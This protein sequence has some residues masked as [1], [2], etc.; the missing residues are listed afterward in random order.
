MA[1]TEQTIQCP[2]CGAEMTKVFLSD[3]GISIDVCNNGCGGIFFDNQELQTINASEND[4]EE[5]KKVLVGK[6]FQ[7]PDSSKV[8]VCPAC[9]SNMVKTKAF[10]TE[11]DTCYNCGA[12]FLDYNEIDSVKLQRHK[13]APEPANPNDEAIG[14]L[15]IHEFYKEAQGE[16]FADNWRDEEIDNSGLVGF[17]R[18]IFF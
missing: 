8:R 16:E 6:E 15:N 1:D 10:G 14:D 13:S 11:I 18:R 12:V 7:V 4:I 9:G 5:I 2:A 17:I 3:A